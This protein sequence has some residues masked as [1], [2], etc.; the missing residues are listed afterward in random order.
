[1]HEPEVIG[2]QGTVTHINDERYSIL[3]GLT[4]A[5]QGIETV[6]SDNVIITSFYYTVS[7]VTTKYLRMSALHHTIVSMVTS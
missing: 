7:M 6:F 2:A 1:M 4:T 3:L 5:Y